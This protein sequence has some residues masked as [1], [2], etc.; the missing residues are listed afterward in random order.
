MVMGTNNEYTQWPDA[1]PCPLSR[2]VFFFSFTFFFPF[3]LI[4]PLNCLLIILWYRWYSKLKMKNWEK[5]WASV[6]ENVR[7][8][9]FFC[10]CD[11]IS[12]IR[13][14][15]LVFLYY[16]LHSIS[17]TWRKASWII[18]WATYASLLTHSWSTVSSVFLPLMLTY[19]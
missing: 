18:S 3:K 6:G 19:R 8:K 16:L 1:E 17:L 9:G 12:I 15:R 4:V 5:I 11:M 13:D 10:L 14:Q 2:P 7:F